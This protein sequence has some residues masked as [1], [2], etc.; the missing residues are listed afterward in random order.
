MAA[1][2]RRDAL[3]RRRQRAMLVFELGELASPFAPCFT[4]ISSTTTPD[5][6][7]VATAMLAD[8][9]PRHHAVMTSMSVVA[10]LN[11]VL[12]MGIFLFAAHGN[13]AIRLLANANDAVSMSVMLLTSA[14]VRPCIKF[15]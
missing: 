12:V 8:G 3:D 2:G 7:P 10:C 6:A 9:Q 4:S 11:P 1:L 14:P 5:T 13:T 15:R